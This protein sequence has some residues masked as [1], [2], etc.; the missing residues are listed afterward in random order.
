V[1]S[2]Y[3]DK[4]QHD[5]QAERY[6]ADV[7]DESNPIRA[8]YSATLKW[9]AERVNALGARTLLEVGPGTGG[10]TGR[11]EGFESIVCVDASEKMLEQAQMRLSG[12]EGVSFVQSDVLEFLDGHEGRF[13]AIVS[14]FALHHLTDDEK[15]E[16][17]RLSLGVLKPGGHVVVGDLMFR[18]KSAKARILN[19]LAAR[20]LSSAIEDVHEAFFWDLSTT[21]AMLEG[22]CCT[23]MK[24]RFSM[25]SWG[26]DYCRMAS[27]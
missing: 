7:A 5:D 11:L 14:T 6:E 27:R 10:L 13:D 23:T 19:A 1:N 15:A 3:V 21:E 12:T 20:G 8:G 2:K 25:L 26:L 16:F 9:V 17:A 22:L 4:F 18:D 24:R